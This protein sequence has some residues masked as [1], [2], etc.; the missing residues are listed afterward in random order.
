[1]KMPGASM[2]MAMIWLK[3]PAMLCDLAAAILLYYTAGGRSK[4][5]E[6]C[7]MAAL[8]LF[9]PAVIFNSSIW[10]QTESCFTFCVLLMCVFLEKKKMFGAIL[11]FGLGMLLKQQTIVFTPVLIYGMLRYVRPPEIKK[12]LLFII[13]RSCVVLALMVLICLPFHIGKSIDY[14]FN[15]LQVFNGA[16]M[17][18][19]NFWALVGRNQVE[20]SQVWLFGIP[21]EMW[22]RVFRILVVLIGGIYV[23]LRRNG[24]VNVAIL[25]ALMIV[26]YFTFGTA[27]HE[28]YLYS[29][30]A[31]LLMSWITE[32]RKSIFILYLF[33]SLLQLLNVWAVY[34][35]ECGTTVVS[36]WLLTDPPALMM[37]CS[38]AMVAGC[39]VF[40]YF[41]FK[42]TNSGVKEDE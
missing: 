36:K 12:K 41:V 30:M 35:A 9:N 2:E 38:A 21:A 31:M 19:F 18:A 23:W 3:V 33:F 22:G 32:K 26:P 20:Q 4:E 6:A 25:G 17:N 14:Y 8:Y 29:A 24:K 42:N 7:T 1:M 40:Y 13:G 11:A 39:L 34:A 28:R 5:K 16:S 27:M 37:G 10:G 15:T